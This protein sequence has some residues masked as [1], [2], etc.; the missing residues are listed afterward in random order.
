MARPKFGRVVGRALALALLLAPLAQGEVFHDP[1]GDVAGAIDGRET[2][3]PDMDLEA[4]TIE[5]HGAQIIMRL[6]LAGFSHEGQVSGLWFYYE[7]TFDVGLSA[8]LLDIRQGRPTDGAWAW[9]VTHRKEE[10][11]ARSVPFQLDREESQVE[12]QIPRHWLTDERGRPLWGAIGVDNLRVRSFDN[13][14][15]GLGQGDNDVLPDDGSVAWSGR[16]GHVDDSLAVKEPL[17]LSNGGAETFEFRVDEGLPGGDYAWRIVDAPADWNITLPGPGPVAAGDAFWV[18]LPSGH[19]HGDIQEVRLELEGEAPRNIVV[20]VGYAN[21]AFP[22]GHHPHLYIHGQDRGDVMGAIMNTDAPSG[23]A[24]VRFD[25]P[26]GR[27]VWDYVLE[28]PLVPGLDVA[29]EA[30]PGEPAGVEL[31]LEKGVQ[32]IAPQVSGRIELRNSSGTFPLWQLD[33]QSG[34]PTPGLERFALNGTWI[35]DGPRIPRGWGELVLVLNV[36]GDG[37][38]QMEAPHLVTGGKLT[39]PL[40]DVLNEVPRLEDPVPLVVEEVLAPSKE[41][42]APIAL[43]PILAALVAGRRR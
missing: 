21:P 43:A 36:R 28:I 7:V 41:S 19:R 16:Y 13:W 27:L 42:P 20:G 31:E 38:N 18:S 30:I 29:L 11:S 6:D 5:D 35:H 1:L 8:H 12:I 15:A 24:L 14:S 32:S 3:W 9:E 17:R 22:G 33:T 4:L 2:V 10:E 37:T 23:K 26:D 25:T 34:L 39:L 40:R